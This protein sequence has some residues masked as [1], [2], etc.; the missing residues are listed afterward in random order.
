MSPFFFFAVMVIIT[1]DE[2]KFF[3]MTT[4]NVFK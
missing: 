4:D 2:S 3:G 1:V